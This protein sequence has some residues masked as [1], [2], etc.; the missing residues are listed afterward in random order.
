MNSASNTQSSNFRGGLTAQST[1]TGKQEYLTSTGGILN[2]GATL[3]GSP[4]PASGLTTA[5]AV[6]IVDGSGNQIT[7]FGGGTQYIDGG[8]V[9]THPTA[10]TLVYDSGGTWQHVSVASP[11]PVSATVTITGVST[12][13]NQTNGTQLTGLVAGT[14]AIGS[15]TNTSFIATQATGTNLHTVVDSGTVTAN[16][17]TNLNTSA[18]A[19]ESGGNLASIKADV[20][21]LAL[22]QGSTTSGQKGNLHLAAVTTTAPTYSTT[23][24]SPLSLDTS[25]NLRT[26]VN[27]TVTITG[28]ISNTSFAVTNAGTFAVQATQSGT[29]T[30]TVT[31]ATGSNLHVVTDSGTITTV[32]TVTAVT[33][34]TNALPAGT[35]GI[36]N[37]G[38]VS[39]A[40]N[41]GQK[42]VN[43]TAVQIS[44]T[45][46]VP[47]NGILIGALSTNAA[48]IFV[49]GS[50]VTT[51]TGVELLPGASIPFTANL[52][53]LFII[54]V[55][56]TTDKVWFN[57]T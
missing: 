54:S 16:A 24:S 49:G 25:G 44:A 32:S 1:I 51:T 50:G 56:S 22:T 55:A 37:V 9:P 26:S 21:N 57:V 19:L 38:T 29:W 33:A 41:V 45:S 46:T 3:S 39:A 53:T 11:L 20:D 40:V 34:I 28:S 42:T 14:A 18:L 52:N 8:S 48:S 23:Q 27:N 35:N 4:I 5:A 43:T 7:S 30:N 6:Q 17:G 31:Q 10:P 47:T 15:I 36:G 2:S 12:A 13:A